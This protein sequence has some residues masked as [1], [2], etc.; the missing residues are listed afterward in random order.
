MRASWTITSV[1]SAAMLF[2]AVLCGGASVY[3]RSCDELP[4]GE[5][6]VSGTITFLRDISC[7]EPRVSD[8]CTDKAAAEGGAAPT[9]SVT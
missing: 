4:P 1:F 5:M 6:V 9:H 7:H 8:V 3:V 2:N